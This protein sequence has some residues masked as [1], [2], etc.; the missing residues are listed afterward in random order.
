L[1]QHPE[2]RREILKPQDEIRKQTSEILDEF[3]LERGKVLRQ[4]A[5]GAHVDMR[6]FY[7]ADGELI[8]PHKLTYEQ[9]CAIEGIEHIPQF[10]GV[11]EERRFVGNKIKY[12]LAK[13]HPFVDMAMKHLGEYKKDNEQGAKALAGSLAELVNGMQGSTIGVVAKIGGQARPIQGD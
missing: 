7:D 11:G 6:G 12:K 2:I 1:L 9:S 10:E 13:R 8:P 4:V 5:I 3:R